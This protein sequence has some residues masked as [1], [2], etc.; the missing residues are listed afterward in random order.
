[1]V[2]TGPRLPYFCVGNPESGAAAPL[3]RH[4]RLAAMRAVD[5]VSRRTGGGIRWSLAAGG[6]FCG[7]QCERSGASLPP[8]FGVRASLVGPRP[9]G[10]RFCTGGAAGGG[11]LVRAK[12]LAGHDRPRRWRRLRAPFPSLE[13]SVWTDLLTSPS[14]RFPGRNP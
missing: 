11:D 4:G 9:L 3:T 7:D 5:L 14:P 10:P 1:M 13:A 2:A 6:G 12:S 8:L